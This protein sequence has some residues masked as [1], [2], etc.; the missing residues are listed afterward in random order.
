VKATLGQLR[1]AIRE[2]R[3]ALVEM[4]GGFL[5]GVPEWQLRQDTTDYVDRIRERIKRF[6]LLNKSENPADQR[7]AIA[8]MNDV[9]DELEKKVYDACE[10]QLFAFTR[11]V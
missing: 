5:N 6:I 7:E 2:E 4:E 10:D 9:C 3:K 1:R 11:R 8:A